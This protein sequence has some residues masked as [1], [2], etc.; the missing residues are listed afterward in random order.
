MGLF[1]FF[2]HKKANH[3]EDEENAKSADT[4]NVES[5]A[6]NA[7]NTDSTDKRSEAAAVTESA[8]NSSNESN[9]NRG[10]WDI[11]EEASIPDQAYLDLGALKIPQ[12]PSMAIRLGISED[13]TRI[14]AVTLTHDGSSLQ[15]TLLAASRNHPLWDE[16]RAAIN[17]G[18]SPHE[19][20]TNFGK[21]VAVDLPLPNGSV[22]PTRIMGIDGPRWMLRAIVTGEAAKGGKAGEYFDELLSQV[23]VDRGET[24]L[25]PKEIVPLTAPGQ[26]EDADDADAQN[27]NNASSD[28]SSDSSQIP[29]SKPKGP[30]SKGVNSREQQILTRKTMFSEVR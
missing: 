4:Q 26:D 16:V 12:K 18:E 22:V 17:K 13:Q 28:D 14:L 1:D 7:V 5:A 9:E 27:A 23:V 15:L 3:Q 8:D 2:H 30:L 25:T 21:G 19:V 10:P 6:E 20:D 11:S 24:P 29:D